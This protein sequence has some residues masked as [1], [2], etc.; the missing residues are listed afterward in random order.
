MQH[1]YATICLYSSA[2]GVGRAFEAIPQTL[3]YIF[4][5]FFIS[6]FLSVSIF[7]SFFF[8][9]SLF[10]KCFRDDALLSPHRRKYKR[11]VSKYIS[12]PK[13]VSTPFYLLSLFT[14]CLIYHNLH[15]SLCTSLSPNHPLFQVLYVPSFSLSHTHMEYPYLNTPFC[16]QSY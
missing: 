2:P 15:L 16:C 14:L 13:S 3:F 10:L 6:L 8:F 5:P 11:R 7:H 9:L 1:S 4:T 12:H